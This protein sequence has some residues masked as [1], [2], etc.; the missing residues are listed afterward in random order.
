M[1]W[2][3]EPTEKLILAKSILP[4]EQETLILVAKAKIA[5]GIRAG[6]QPML[7]RGQ[8]GH[9]VLTSYRVAFVAELEGLPTSEPYADELEK[10]FK[11]SKVF[12]NVPLVY[13]PEL[14]EHPDSYSKW[15]KHMNLTIERPEGVQEVVYVKA[16]GELLDFQRTSHDFFKQCFAGPI[17]FYTLLE[18]GVKHGETTE[19][20]IYNLVGQ[21][22]NTQMTMVPES[23]LGAY[24]K[25]A[26]TVFNELVKFL[27]KKGQGGYFDSVS[28][29]L[30]LRGDHVHIS[31]EWIAHSSNDIL[32][33]KIQQL[34]EEWRAEEEAKREKLG[35]RYEITGF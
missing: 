27:G 14:Q 17:D 11:Q 22:I 3:L 4:K 21:R 15:K 12:I 6:E 1:A 8:E 19:S 23:M 28:R 10:A 2:E 31:E 25:K 16:T 26:Q 5:K 18:S 32:Q 13:L 29:T 33:Q 9:F 34:I 35:D 24:Q 30:A 20:T 7:V